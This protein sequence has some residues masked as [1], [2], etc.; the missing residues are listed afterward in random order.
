M[1]QLHRRPPGRRHRF[2]ADGARTSQ[3]QEREGPPSPL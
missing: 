2:R 1:T 3:R